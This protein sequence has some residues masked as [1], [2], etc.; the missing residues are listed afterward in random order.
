[1]TVF[2]ETT[3][4]HPAAHPKDGVFFCPSPFKRTGLFLPKK[5]S[6]YGPI[7]IP[8]TSHTET[9]MYSLYVF[10]TEMEIGVH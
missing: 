10:P 6:D 7:T 5:Q 3:F 9:N 8:K 2:I 1:M 4:S